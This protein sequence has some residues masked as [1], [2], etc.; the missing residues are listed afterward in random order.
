MMANEYITPDSKCPCCGYEMDRATGIDDS[1]PKPKHGDIA[2]CIHC[3]EP[4]TFGPD[5]RLRQ[6]TVTDLL[7]LGDDGLRQ[8]EAVQQAIRKTRAQKEP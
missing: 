3:T 4:L 2:I 5:L 7:E 8:I 6:A 1:T